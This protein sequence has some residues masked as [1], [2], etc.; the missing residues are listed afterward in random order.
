MS[1]TLHLACS[2]DPSYTSGKLQDQRFVG[3]K[4]NYSNYYKGLSWNSRLAPKKVKG[5]LL[6][7]IHKED[8]KRRLHQHI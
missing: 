5:H 8:R 4:E 2:T 3:F 7:N 6:D 1:V